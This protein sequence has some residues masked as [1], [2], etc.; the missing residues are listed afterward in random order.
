M[1]RHDL[2]FWLSITW[3]VGLCGAAGWVFFA[4]FTLN[5]AIACIGANDGTARR[6]STPSFR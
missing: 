1:T 6:R 5:N 4:P 2:F 3:L